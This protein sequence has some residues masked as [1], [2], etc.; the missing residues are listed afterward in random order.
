MAL[1]R[2]SFVFRIET[3]IPAT[4]W[5]GHGDLVLPADL[6]LAEPTVAMGGGHLLDVPD[7]D[8]LLNGTAQRLEIQL[9]GV[10]EET[11]ALALDEA[12]QVPGAAVYIGRVEFDD[13]WQL[14]GPVAWE[15]S[16]T[17]VNLSVTSE[18]TENGRTRGLTLVIASGDTTRRRASLSFFTDADQRRA[19][20]TDA[21][22]SHV[23]GITAG[24]SRRWGPK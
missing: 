16:G 5:T 19:F 21:I 17:G 6:V 15:W 2:E 22:F 13:S 10:D 4:V 18:S 8:Q 20:P 12:A 14:T 11:I 7:F 3:D 1:Y 23:G 9:S 24:T